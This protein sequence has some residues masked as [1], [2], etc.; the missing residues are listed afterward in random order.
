MKR[1]TQLFCLLIFY[2]IYCC[3][4]VFIMFSFHRTIHVRKLYLSLKIGVNRGMSNCCISKVFHWIPQL[5]NNNSRN[6]NI[7]SFWYISLFLLSLK[8]KNFLTLG[9][10][11]PV[12]LVC[13]LSKTRKAARFA[14]YDATIIIA[15]PAQTIPNTLAEKLRGVPVE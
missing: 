8:K 15:K 5:Q 9:S 12:K 1:C 4:R 7:E 11:I 13:G 10:F 14:V 6:Q 2:S 3:V